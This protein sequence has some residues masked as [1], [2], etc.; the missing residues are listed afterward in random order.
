MS[1]PDIMGIL[2]DAPRRSAATPEFS[3]SAE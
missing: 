3:L 1:A 2:V